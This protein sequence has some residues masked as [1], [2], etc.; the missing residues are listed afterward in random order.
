MSRV[1]IVGG[2]VVGFTTA[3][4]IAN[5]ASSHGVP[6]KIELWSKEFTP[7][8]TSDIAGAS[9]IPT[10]KVNASPDIQKWVKHTASV[11]YA[12]AENSSTTGVFLYRGTETLPATDPAPWYAPYMA[13]FREITPQLPSIDASLYRSYEYTTPIVDM[14]H[15][16]PWLMKHAQACGVTLRQRHVTKWSQ[17]VTDHSNQFDIIINC[18]GLGARY[19]VG[20]QSVFP[21]IG[22]VAVAKRP[23]QSQPLQFHRMSFTDGEVA[24]IYPRQSII[25]LGGTYIPQTESKDQTEES[26]AKAFELT[27]E[28]AAKHRQ[29]ILS[30]CAVIWPEV[31]SLEISKVTFGER[32]Y[33]AKV[34]VEAEVK[35]ESG[36]MIVHNYG[37]GGQGVLLS[38]GCAR[39]V[40]DL[41][42]Q[43]WKETGKVSGAEQVAW[44]RQPFQLLSKL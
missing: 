19:L 12:L 39:D 1:L 36:T 15:H 26:K 7:N 27:A 3:L 22:V 6:L 16:M 23:A 43:R 8:T 34:R 2:G 42:V 10:D 30:R 37:H 14:S 28:L 32:P 18:T 20:D 25:V 44:K 5:A 41:V 21:M 17:F 24:Y 29:Q 4:S 13:G 33:R 35:K 31:R 38:W 9:F 11:L 40:A